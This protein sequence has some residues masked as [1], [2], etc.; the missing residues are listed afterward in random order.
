MKKSR[1]IDLRSSSVSARTPLARVTPSTTSSTAVCTSPWN[2]RIVVRVGREE[3]VVDAAEERSAADRI[4]PGQ[5][6]K[7][8]RPRDPQEHYAPRPAGPHR[9]TLGRTGA[10]ARGA[11]CGFPA[12][13]PQSEPPP[14]I[15]DT[16]PDDPPPAIPPIINPDRFEDF[17]FL[18]ETFML[19]VSDPKANASLRGMA[20]LLFELILEYW[21]KWSDQPEGFLRASLRAAVADMR[22]V[23]GF[24][25]ELE[26]GA[27]DS[28]HEEHLAELGA[29]IAPE[30]GALADRLEKELGSWRG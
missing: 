19:Y 3:A 12:T 25:A 7:P 4:L 8:R 10:A 28:P 11:L 30:I 6:A 13:P 26:E 24:L 22:S 20:D 23:Q 5:L 14:P 2:N 1:R 29:S 27:Q 18:R 16:P 17:P 9:L 15:S 21:G